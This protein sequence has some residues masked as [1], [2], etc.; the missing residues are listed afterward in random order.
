M[1][2]SQRLIHLYGDPSIDTIKWEINNMMIWNISPLIHLSIEC[3]PKRIYIHKK[4]QPIVEKWFIALIE[5]G[6]HNE[7]MTY[8]GC[9]NVRKKR[10]LKSLSI[11]AFG[12]AIDLNASHNPLGYTREQCIAKGLKPFTNKFIQVSRKYVDCGFDWSTR[13]DG[14]HFQIKKEQSE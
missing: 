13:V 7:I 10:G 11:H 3:L 8:D 4:F 12:M 2:N 6:V 1:V 9:W 14:M 5:N